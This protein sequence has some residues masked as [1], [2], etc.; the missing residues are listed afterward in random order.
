MFSRRGRFPAPA[1]A[2]PRARIVAIDTRRHTC[3]IS[4]IAAGVTLRLRSPMPNSSIVYSGLP[5]IWPH[6][7]IGTFVL[8]GR[9]HRHV[10]QPQ[11]RR[12]GRRVQAGHVLVAAV[13]RQR[14]LNQVV[15]ADAEEIHLVARSDPSSSRPT[16]PRP[17]CRPSC[18]GRTATPSSSRSSIAS[19]STILACRSSSSVLTSGNMMLMLPVTLAR[20]IARSCVRNMSRMLQRQPNAP[21][22]QERIALVLGNGTARHLVGAQVDRPH[23]DRLVRASP[24]PLRE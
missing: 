3:L 11:H 2:R 5:H 24:R 10:D 6:M 16:A 17:S 15:R 9:P 19:R 13:D 22:A 12:V 23:H 1:P 18:R 14:V 4:G 8:V 7:L 21:Q 20:R